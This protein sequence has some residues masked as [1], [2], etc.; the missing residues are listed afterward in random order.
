[1]LLEVAETDP[2]A[3]L[4]Q[5]LVRARRRDA[6]RPHA[7]SLRRLLA[8]RYF[9]VPR[10]ARYR[11]KRDP[12]KMP[13]KSIPPLAGRSAV[14]SGAASGTG[15]G[16]AVRLGAAGCPLALTDVDEAGLEETASMVATATLPRRLDVSER[17]EQL[18][19]AAEVAEWAPAPIG[20]V[21]N[22]A[23]VALAATV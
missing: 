7:V 20:A 1:A 18:A 4:D 22:N 15:R 8:C 16:L 13:A 10:G 23:G 12:P 3:D 17:G 6:A 11:K 19:F 14:I 2:A 21:F 9:E 5:L